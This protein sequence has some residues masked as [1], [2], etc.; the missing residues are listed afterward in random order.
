MPNVRGLTLG[1]PW[2]ENPGTVQL[3]RHLPN[4]ESLT[5]MLDPHCPFIKVSE[6]LKVTGAN[7]KLL[8]IV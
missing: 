4:L 5:I 3:L 2:E 1:S 7:V 8:R 6:A